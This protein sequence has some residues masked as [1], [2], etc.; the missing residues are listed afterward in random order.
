MSDARILRFVMYLM[1]DGEVGTGEGDEDED[2]TYERRWKAIKFR[3]GVR[4]A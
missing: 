2:G 3:R 1:E 4:V